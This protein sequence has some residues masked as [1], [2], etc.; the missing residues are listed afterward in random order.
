MIPSIDGV[1]LPGEREQANGCDSG[2]G[3]GATGNGDT[4][5]FG[6]EWLRSAQDKPLNRAC[7]P[8]PQRPRE[9]VKGV[10]SSAIGNSHPGPLWWTAPRAGASCLKR[11]GGSTARWVCFSRGRAGGTTARHTDI[12]ALG[13]WDDAKPLAIKNR[14]TKCLVSRFG[15]VEVCGRLLSCPNLLAAYA[16]QG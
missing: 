11:G 4:P 15:V 7:V 10:R 3:A 2:C 16:R 1:P 6:V 14:R 12:P 8:W 9:T 13:P 5:F